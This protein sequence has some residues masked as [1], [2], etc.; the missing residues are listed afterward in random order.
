MTLWLIVLFRLWTALPFSVWC[1]IIPIL[2]WLASFPMTVYLVVRD[3]VTKIAF[4]FI[5]LLITVPITL[6][7]VV[8]T[9]TKDL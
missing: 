1:V 8:R 5:F 2:R 3:K 6:M 4:H 9:E 7:I